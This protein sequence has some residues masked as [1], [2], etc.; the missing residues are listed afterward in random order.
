MAYAPPS[1]QV[2]AKAAGR[3][4][5]IA[6]THGWSLPKVFNTDGAEAV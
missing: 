5:L 4:K 3:V 1:T 6:M 2:A